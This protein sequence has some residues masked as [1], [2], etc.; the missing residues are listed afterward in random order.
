MILP[1]GH[2]DTKVRRLPWVTFGIMAVCVGVMAFIDPSINPSADPSL[3]F[4]RF[5]LVPETPSLTGF[6]G[7]IFRGAIFVGAFRGKLLC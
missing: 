4:S 2:D 6:F 1:I 3:I 7:H 5:G